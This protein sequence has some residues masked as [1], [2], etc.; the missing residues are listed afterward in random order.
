MVRRSHVTVGSHQ[1]IRDGELVIVN[2][3]GNRG[4]AL[5]LIAIRRARQE[6]CSRLN[7]CKP[8]GMKDENEILTLRIQSLIQVKDA[9]SSVG[10]LIEAERRGR[11]VSHEWRRWEQENEYR[12]ECY[13]KV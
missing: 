9:C 5:K 7:I 13:S 6:T 3:D 4:N 11:N 1:V 2:L 12:I 10:S 8:Y